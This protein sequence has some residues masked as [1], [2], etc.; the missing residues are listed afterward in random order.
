MTADG[1]VAWF[2]VLLWSALW[3]S[4]Q[5][6]VELG[7]VGE[8]VCECEYL[9]SVLWCSFA[10]PSTQTV[11]DKSLIV[12]VTGSLPK[13]CAQPGSSPSAVLTTQRPH[14]P[15]RCMYCK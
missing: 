3:L 8:V 2:A 7:A 11:L 15:L 14:L 1:L 9:L 13:F 10:T 5:V 12:S 4:L 6:L